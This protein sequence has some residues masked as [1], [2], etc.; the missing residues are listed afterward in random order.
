MN[1]LKHIRFSLPLRQTR[2]EKLETLQ[3]SATQ[4]LYLVRVDGLD[5][6]LL[7]GGGQPII[8]PTISKPHP[9][10]NPGEENI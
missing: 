6:L 9:C 1:I 10:P 5:Y 2:L 3:L 7:S 8:L 4:S